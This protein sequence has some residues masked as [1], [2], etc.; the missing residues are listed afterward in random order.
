MAKSIRGQQSATS[1]SAYCPDAGD[2][3]HI[4]FEP[5]V[6]REQAKARP[7]LV[8]TAQSYNQ[9]TRLCILCP[10]TSQIKGYPF[11]VRLPDE[12][13]VVGV[14]LVDQVKSLSWEFRRSQLMC[15]APNGVLVEVKAKLRALLKL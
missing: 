5:H 8:L 15:A 3:I 13:K 14:V 4:N 9:K 1:S 12:C 10:I 11:E 6:G 7:A 2:I